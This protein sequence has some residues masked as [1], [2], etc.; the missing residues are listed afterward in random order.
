MTPTKLLAASAAALILACIG[1]ATQAR[2]PARPTVQ[3]DS[4][5]GPST[6]WPAFVRNR[7]KQMPTENFTDY[8]FRF[9]LSQF[10]PT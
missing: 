7:A 6:G 2:T 9:Q 4:F 8:T 3:I 1:G 10:P 5:G